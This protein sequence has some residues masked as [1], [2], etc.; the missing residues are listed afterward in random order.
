V[1]LP[2]GYNSETLSPIAFWLDKIGIVKI[3]SA[4]TSPAKDPVACAQ[5][6]GTWNVSLL[7]QAR[8]L[9]TNPTS[10]IDKNIDSAIG[11][12]FHSNFD[13]TNI[14]VQIGQALG[15]YLFTKLDLDTAG[16]TLSDGGSYDPNSGGVLSSI[17]T[18]DLDNDGI[19]DVQ[20][21]DGNKIVSEGD[22]CYHG[23]V[24]PGAVPLKCLASGLVPGSAYFTPICKAADDAIDE[25]TI[26]HDFL[27]AHQD[28]ER[29]SA[30]LI[31]DP[32]AQLY[33]ERGS[34]VQTRMDALIQAVKVFNDRNFDNNLFELNRFNIWL[35]A[36]N[37]SL[38]KDNDVD[39]SSLFGNGVGGGWVNLRNNTAAILQYV[40]DFR[41]VIKKCDA[42]DSAAAGALAP[43]VLGGTDPLP[44]GTGTGGTGCEVGVS[45]NPAPAQIASPD[46]IGA[47]I[48]G[49]SPADVLSWPVTATITNVD[50]NQ[51]MTFDPDKMVGGP[52]NPVW[53]NVSF[54]VNY[55][56]W[57]FLNIGGRWVGSGFLQRYGQVDGQHDNSV[58]FQLPSN[59]YYGSQWTPMF[60]HALAIGEQVGFM[61]TSGDAR[62]GFVGTVKERSQVFLMTLPPDPGV[63]TPS[64]GGTPTPTPTP[65]PTAPGTTTPGSPTITSVAPTSVI[66]GQTT[67]T[68]TGTNLTTTVQFFD[69]AGNRFTPIVGG[70]VNAAKTQTTILV[71]AELPAGNGTVRIW[72]SDTS[73]SSTLPITVTN[74]GTSTGSGPTV[75]TVIPTSSWQPQQSTN[76][77][78]PALSPDG[79]YVNYGNWGE[80]WITDLT[81][82]QNFDFRSP[83][84]LPAGA[85][86]IAGQWITADTLSFVCD[87]QN[88]TFWRY[89]VKAGEW[90][91]RKTA[92]DPNLV[93]GN[94]E[95]A[96]DGH[97]A[98]AL[99][100]GGAFRIAKDNAV[101]A[102]GAGGNISL[103]GNQLVAGCNN[104]NTTLCVW[105]GTS[106]LKTLI[107]QVP[108]FD[109]TTNAGYIVYGGAGTGLHGITPAGIDSNLKLTP[110][111]NEG[112]N[113]IIFVGATPWVVTN[114][115]AGTS[116][117]IFLRPYGSA[118]A[119]AIGAE[120]GN[121]SVRISGTDFVIAYNNGQ[122]RLTVITVPI[123]SPRSVMPQ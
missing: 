28:L 115:W 57:L 56:Y 101:L 58:Y 10:F 123:N 21:N 72:A 25:L 14:Y 99:S 26:Y 44:G 9:I 19:P 100:S 94:T 116:G 112:V 95:I 81:T 1:P 110:L 73:F 12:I 108:L 61:V 30:N 111:I 114:G 42:P 83:P 37:R 38:Y 66:A 98:S 88:G 65:T 32:D 121:I 119:I 16:N 89:E 23:E 46:Q 80:N 62:G 120:A 77:W 29:G 93:A 109:T 105:Q 85:R 78:W 118:S 2:T 17:K 122:G 43:P 71:P 35:D 45:P 20:D 91:A 69:A 113:K 97:W 4:Q 50:A 79:R 117:Y 5:L 47:T 7:D 90:I 8:S 59:W 51:N 64:S 3:A 68:I 102:T 67:I 84:G 76:N 53:P 86:C 63:C 52:N 27:I 70:S 107:P 60:Q 11:A 96:G 49:G 106:L 22:T 92:D 41:V 24:T 6:G 39:L 55:T 33:G 40:K 104:N 18:I 54:G 82:K 74:T 87:L 15:S 34:L 103:S 36:V 31:H 75:T 48:V 13:P